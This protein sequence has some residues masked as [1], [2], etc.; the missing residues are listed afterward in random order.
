M[1]KSGVGGSVG[2]GGSERGEERSE[3]R[4]RANCRC[5]GVEEAGGRWD[6]GFEGIGM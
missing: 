2:G 6:E 1:R 5:V 4:L 3:G